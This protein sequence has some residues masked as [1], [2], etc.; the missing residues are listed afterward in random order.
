MNSFLRLSRYSTNA[1]PKGWVKL[2]GNPAT[3][4]P[5]TNCAD[6]TDFIKNIKQELPRQLS[7]FDA[8]EILTTNLRV[9]FLPYSPN[10]K[11]WVYSLPIG[12]GSFSFSC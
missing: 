2:N 11:I 5:T 4:V 10:R 3:K 12:F 1:F 9:V 8:N 6:I 7:S